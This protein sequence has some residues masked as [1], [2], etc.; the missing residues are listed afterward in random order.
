VASAPLLRDVC[1]LSEQFGARSR[2]GVKAHGV[3]P[4]FHI[5]IRKLN[6]KLNSRFT[7]GEGREQDDVIFTVCQDDL[8]VRSYGRAILCYTTCSSSRP[9]RNQDRAHVSLAAGTTGNASLEN[10]VL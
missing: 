1:W 4:G 7:N 5:Q 9:C 8:F 2:Q 3:Q 6:F 10:T